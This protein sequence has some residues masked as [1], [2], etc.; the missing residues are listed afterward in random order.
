M[1]VRWGAKIINTHLIR[2]LRIAAALLIF[3]ITACSGGSTVTV[4]GSS[5]GRPEIRDV[6]VAAIPTA[7]LLGLYIA[8]DDGFFARQGLHVSIKKI[9]SSQSVIAAQLAGQV[10]IGAGSYIPYISAQASGARFRILAEGSTLRAGTRAL[11]VAAGSPIT[12]IADLIGKRIG[13]NNTNSIGTLLIDALLTESGI[14]PDK[15]HLVTDPAGFP[16]MPA[17]LKAGQ[18][19]AVFLAEPYITLA[20][21][22]YGGR[23]L[24]DLDAGATLNFPVDGYVATQ[25]WAQRY[26]ATA[27]A[28]TRAIEEGQA[29]AGTDQ[30]QVEQAMRNA[31]G[32][33]SAITAIMTTP[34]FPTGPVDETRIQRVAEAM[35]DFGL[36]RSQFSAEVS[37]GALTRAMVSPPGS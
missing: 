23:V 32:L 11:V 25:A 21:E 1:P 20:E 27:A 16:A 4:T 9:A 34:Q 28:F 13:V 5:S 19:S 14:A 35:L 17:E 29:V 10:D 6:T 24:A 36:L 33:P 12:S 18:W 3:A 31:E 22:Q 2:A 7:D 30:S 26:P 8:Q 37:D 15:V